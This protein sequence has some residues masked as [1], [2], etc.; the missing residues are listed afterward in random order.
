MKERSR[1]PFWK[2]KKVIAFIKN[3]INDIKQNKALGNQR[4][5][6][7]LKSKSTEASCDSSSNL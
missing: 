2:E 6:H 1:L 3:R 5:L 4:F 7:D